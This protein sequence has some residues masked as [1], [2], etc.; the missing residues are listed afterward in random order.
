MQLWLA[1]AFEEKLFGLLFI[2]TLILNSYSIN[3]IDVYTLNKAPNQ[4]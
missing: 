4:S 2:L 1:I 3:I